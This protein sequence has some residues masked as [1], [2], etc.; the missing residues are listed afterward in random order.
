MKQVH[1]LGPLS[2]LE[3]KVKLLQCEF[4]KSNYNPDNI[5]RK[6]RHESGVCVERKRDASH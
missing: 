3:E 1:S 6:K 4:C 5:K 2:G